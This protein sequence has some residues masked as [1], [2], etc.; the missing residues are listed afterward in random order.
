MPKLLP[1]L[2]LLLMTIPRPAGALPN[3][4]WLPGSGKLSL[5]VAT[6][7]PFLVMSELSVG[8]TDHAALGLLG[9]TTPIVSGFGVRPRGAVPLADDWRL[10]LS[11]PI[12]FYPQRADG[13]AWWLARPSSE[14][15]WRPS[16]GLSLA[17]G[18]GV[19]GIATQG[20]LFGAEADVTASSSYGR[21]L[22]RQRTD[23]WWT[24]NALVSVAVSERTQVFADAT[25]VFRGF[26]PA[27]S[28]WIGGPPLI[29]FLGVSTAL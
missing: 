19:V 20:A 1:A 17:A 4:A 29:L 15:E 9:G 18:A 7:V 21:Q 14:L 3:D 2:S 6:G 10:L 16:A 11:A 28:A 13:P 8:V 5:A 23:L 26:L 25:G 24:V 22:V 27:D 12:V